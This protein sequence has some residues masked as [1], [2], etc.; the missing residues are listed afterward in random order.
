MEVN[1]FLL[2][3]S[4]VLVA[5]IIAVIIYCAAAALHKREG[6]AGAAVRILVT[7]LAPATFLAFSGLFYWPLTLGVSLL[8]AAWQ[9]AALTPQLLGRVRDVWNSMSLV[10]K[11][12]LLAL[13]VA[14][15]FRAGSALSTPSIDGDSLLYHLPMSAA[16]IQDHSMWSTRALLYP[17]AAELGAAIGGAATGNVNGMVAF[18]MTTIFV[19]GL[20]AFGWARKAGASVDGAAATSII[21][22]ALPIVVD[23]MFTSQNDILFCTVLAAACV[24][25]RSSPRLAGLS[26][27][28]AASVK[29]TALA[30]VPAVALVMIFFDGWPFSVAD[31]AWAAS[32]AAP[33]YLRTWVLTGTPLYTVA[34]MGWSS[35]IAANFASSWRFVLS[36]LRTYGGLAAGAGAV[37]LVFLSMA[38]ERNAFAR[39]LPWLALMAF[40]SWIVLPNS[41]ESVPGTLDQ[42]RQ[43]WSLRY[44]VLLPFV[45]ATAL[46][47]ALDRVPRLPLAA[48][49]ALVAAAS[50]IVRSAN[51]TAS[52]EPLGF[53]YAIPVL[54]A[55]V[56]ITIALLVRPSV[57][58]GNRSVMGQAAAAVAIAIIGLTITVGAQSVRRLWNPSYLQWSSL[59]PV[60][61]VILDKHILSSSK[62]AIVGMRSFAFVGPEF[63]RQTY[64]NIIIET[65]A[66][67]LARLRRSGVS[68]LAAAGESGSPDQPGFLQPLPVETWISHAA[69]VCKIAT[70]NYVRVY[71]LT[72]T[73]CA[74]PN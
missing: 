42:I 10:S 20:V 33:W 29:L 1:I 12:A 14:C 55:L 58:G 34:S 32:I 70:Y 74:R 27:G 5:Y 30:V 43:G 62:V 23:Q 54:I 8:A 9:G 52:N 25:W 67:W 40:A 44:A 51:L 65:P 50:A 72:E 69:G 17:G 71:G 6:P 73:R 46:P 36:A 47:I 2:A 21:A 66:S 64:D 49:A 60:S 35:T 63:E 48:F 31:I 39:A 56:L 57:E 18:Q 3:R 4:V 19:L 28:L 7:L 53:F 16:L 41:A 13:S 45:L 26:L 37:A 24:L 11:V 15:A 61:S 59:I 38:R 68:I 22:V